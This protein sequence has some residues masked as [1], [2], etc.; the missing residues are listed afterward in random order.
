M[1]VYIERQSALNSSLVCDF[2][3]RWLQSQDYSIF[4]VL[5]LIEMMKYEI[6]NYSKTKITENPKLHLAEM[7]KLI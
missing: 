7:V 3:L 4:S 6:H 2:L 5:I 1:L